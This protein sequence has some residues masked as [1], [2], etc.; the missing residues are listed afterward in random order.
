MKFVFI[1]GAILPDQK[2][3]S[4]EQT[5]E[6]DGPDEAGNAESELNWR[7]ESA[8][9]ILVLKRQKGYRQS[10]LRGIISNGKWTAS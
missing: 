3:S 5:Q 7:E 8:Q 10:F 1:F 6:E 2:I 9:Q 4:C